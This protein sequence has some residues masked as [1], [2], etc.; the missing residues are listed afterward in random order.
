MRGL[1]NHDHPAAGLLTRAN[2]DL[3]TDPRSKR[4]ASR[5]LRQVQRRL[6]PG[7]IAVM[8]EAY[9]SGAR[10]GEVADQFGVHPATVARSLEPEGV[11]ER[12]RSLSDVA[13]RQAIDLYRRA[14]RSR[15][16]AAISGSRIRRS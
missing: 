14:S 16:S 10:I 8:V 4:S 2:D 11:R 9:R 1:S 3:P 6:V 12:T 7:E 13:I 15:Q 5:P